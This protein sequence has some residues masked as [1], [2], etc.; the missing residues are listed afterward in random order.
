MVASTAELSTFPAPVARHIRGAL[1]RNEDVVQNWK[2]N[3]W[4]ALKKKPGAMGD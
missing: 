4:P 1:E 3:T 2:R